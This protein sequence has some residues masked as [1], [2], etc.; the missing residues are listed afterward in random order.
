[1]DEKLRQAWYNGDRLQGVRFAL[2]D[3]VTVLRGSCKGQTGSV[4]SLET[5]EPEPAYDVELSDTGSTVTLRQED[6]AKA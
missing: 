6:L 1:M 4:I 3:S 5:V 2:N